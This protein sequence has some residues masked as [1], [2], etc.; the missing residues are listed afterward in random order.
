VQSHPGMSVAMLE[1][2]DML[3]GALPLILHHHER[4]DGTGYPKQLGG[5]NIPRGASIIAVADAFVHMQMARPYRPA[6][7]QQS[8]L[9][10]L[11]QES[12][13]QFDPTAVQALMKSLLQEVTGPEAA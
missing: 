8:V 11:K 6:M 13:K 3:K 5:V 12:G 9:A 4:Y 1:P 7:T 2:F 10:Y